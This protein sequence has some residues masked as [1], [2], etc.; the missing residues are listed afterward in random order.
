[1]G[2]VKSD[3]LGDVLCAEDCREEAFEPELEV[4][5]P[6]FEEEL[7]EGGVFCGVWDVR[8][9]VVCDKL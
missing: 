4:C 7:A 1:M 5:S 3:E 2:V 8:E 6:L 9:C